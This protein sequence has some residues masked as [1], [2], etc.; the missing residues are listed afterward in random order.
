MSVHTEEIGGFVPKMT[1]SS[2]SR[3]SRFISHRESGP[4][5]QLTLFSHKAYLEQMI[6]LL[7][8]ISIVICLAAFLAIPMLR[9]QLYTAKLED[10]QEEHHENCYRLNQTISWPPYLFRS[11]LKSLS[12]LIGSAL[13][14]A[15][16]N[17]TID[18][19]VDEAI[20]GLNERLMEYQITWPL[21]FS[22]CI[23]VII[24]DV[25][26]RIRRI[27]NHLYDSA[28]M[29]GMSLMLFTM[30]FMRA[31]ETYFYYNLLT[32]V[33]SILSEV[34]KAVKRQAVSQKETIPMMFCLEPPKIHFAVSMLGLFLSVLDIT[35]ILDYMDPV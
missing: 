32:S 29:F 4:V 27:Q 19:I 16:D 21:D 22:C 23:A 2:L 6:M 30:T 11:G 5:A 14:Y 18:Q 26:R 35:M 10:C 12:P 7:N 33:S 15:K 13:V 9:I 1:R 25:I 3:V 8:I 17:G 24:L 20:E 34:N 28:P 31:V